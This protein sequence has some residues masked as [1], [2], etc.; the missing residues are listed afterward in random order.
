MTEGNDLKGQNEVKEFQQLSKRE[1]QGMFRE[2]LR[3]LGQD[4][5]WW[6][7]PIIIMLLVFGVLVILSSGIAAPFIYTLF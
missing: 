4:R 7:A 5:N 1:S 6:L 3:L 2:M